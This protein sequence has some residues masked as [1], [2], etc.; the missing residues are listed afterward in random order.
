[1]IIGAESS[2]QQPDGALGDINQQCTRLLRSMALPRSFRSDLRR[3]ILMGAPVGYAT[4]LA[5]YGGI[6]YWMAGSTGL[7]VGCAIATFFAAI[8]LHLCLRYVETITR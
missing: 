1:L 7:L 8:G 4:G 2:S 6:G 3:G 5:L